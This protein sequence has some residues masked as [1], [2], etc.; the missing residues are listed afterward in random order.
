MR[1]IVVTEHKLR[2]ETG[3][4]EGL[5]GYGLLNGGI[6]WKG[7]LHGPMDTRTRLTVKFKTWDIDM[8]KHRWRFR[9]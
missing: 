5:G 7:H 4:K 2:R 6:G 1:A 9:K 3:S 8:R